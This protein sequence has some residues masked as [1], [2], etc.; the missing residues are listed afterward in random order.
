MPARGIR[1][2]DLTS[3]KVLVTENI[4][5]CRTEFSIYFGYVH[6]KTFVPFGSI[7]GFAGW[8]GVQCVFR[9]R[10]VRGHANDLGI[11]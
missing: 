5:C 7:R 11:G 10:F 6:D 3:N 9:F 8:A 1:K 4:R 2:L